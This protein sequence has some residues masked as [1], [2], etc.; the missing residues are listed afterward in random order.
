MSSVA[1]RENGGLAASPGTPVS[2]E[3]IPESAEV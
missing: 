3:K 1:W 2:A